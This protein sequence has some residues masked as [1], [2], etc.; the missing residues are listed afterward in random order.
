MGISAAVYVHFGSNPD[1][2][3]FNHN[4][5][6]SPDSGHRVYGLACPLSAIAD[7]VLT[8]NNTRFV[9]NSSW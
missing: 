9:L 3:R 2:T 4:V 6:F 7:M 8:L 1:V 5:R